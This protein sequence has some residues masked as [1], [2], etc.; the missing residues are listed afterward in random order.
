MDI[1]SDATKKVQRDRRVFFRLLNTIKV[2]LGLLFILTAIVW[3]L[4]FTHPVKLLIHANLAEYYRH[5]GESDYKFSLSDVTFLKYYDKQF[6]DFKFLDSCPNLGALYL[7]RCDFGSFAGFDR[8]KSIQYLSM[9]KCAIDDL[10]QLNQLNRLK[11]LAIAEMPHFEYNLLNDL[12]ELKQ[13][14]IHQSEI[15][16][17]DWVPIGLE[18][19]NVNQC[20]NLTNIEGIINVKQL[21]VL[22]LSENSNRI[23]MKPIQS[24]DSLVLKLVDGSE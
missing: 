6:E 19:F 24:L 12:V 18:E 16:N 14:F 22:D 8:L 2:M 11:T 5:A 7:T 4:P 10:S 17:L 23:N 3:L 20:V 15:A 9:D 1:P 13:L 21:K